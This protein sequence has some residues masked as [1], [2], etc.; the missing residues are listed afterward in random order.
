MTRWFFVS[1]PFTYIVH[2]EWTMSGRIK[3]Y[4]IIMFY[5][6]HCKWG[7]SLSFSKFHSRCLAVAYFPPKS[8]LVSLLNLFSWYSCCL[9]FCYMWTNKIVAMLVIFIIEFLLLQNPTVFPT[10]SSIIFLLLR[11]EVKL[12][13]FLLLSSFLG[14]A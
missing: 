13:T 1:V 4:T 2:V 11:L 5:K 7:T 3:Y 10:K 9:F 12:T 14:V 8:R 6:Q